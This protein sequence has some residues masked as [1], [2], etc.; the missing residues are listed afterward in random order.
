MAATYRDRHP[1]DL[2]SYNIGIRVVRDL[3]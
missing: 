3:D 2:F 1:A